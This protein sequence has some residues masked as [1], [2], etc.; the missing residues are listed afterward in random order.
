MSCES[1]AIRS[2]LADTA[3]SRTAMR[4]RSSSMA[5]PR[6]AMSCLKPSFAARLADSSSSS[7]VIRASLA[8]A[9][10]SC[11]ARVLSLSATP[12]ESAATFASASETASRSAATR[13]FSTSSWASL[14]DRSLPSSAILASPADSCRSKPRLRRLR[15]AIVASLAVNSPD[16]PAMV[17]SLDETR[18]SNSDTRARKFAISTSRSSIRTRSPDIS[19]TRPSRLPASRATSEAFSPS[20]ACSAARR[21]FLAAACWFSSAIVASR[22]DRFAVRLAIV[23]SSSAILPSSAAISAS[24][25]AIALFKLSIEAVLWSS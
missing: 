10:S 21:S 24:F 15:P 13:A 17:S 20:C 19:S 12:L 8:E 14:L 18:R 7:P 1:A 5:S 11:A 2:S 4:F 16:R 25:P 23:S 9:A 3:C 6:A 22:D